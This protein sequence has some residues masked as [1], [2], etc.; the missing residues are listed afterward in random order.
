VQDQFARARVV[1][2]AV[3]TSIFSVATVATATS[4]NLHS[5][6]DQAILTAVEPASET[7]E[8]TDGSVEIADTVETV[9]VQ[10][11]A[12][13]DLAPIGHRTYSKADNLPSSGHVATLALSDPHDP[14]LPASTFS[15]RAQQTT[16]TETDAYSAFEQAAAGSQQAT[17]TVVAR[18]PQAKPRGA[19]RADRA[20]IVTT[21]AVLAYAPEPSTLDAPFDAVLRG[22][23][24]EIVVQGG[25][26]SNVTRPRPDPEELL[27]WLEGRALGQFAPD[28][29]D[30]VKNPLP[31]SVHTAKEQKCLA[32]GIYF[33]ARGEPE[34]GQAAVAQV[35]LNRVRNPT[36]PDTI[37]GVV[38]QNKG[39][40]NR[41]QFSF[42]CDGIPDKV[43]S[44][45]AWSTARSIASD[46]T[47]G[48]I[49]IE[50]VGDSTHY[51]ADYVRPKWARAMNKM[52][53]IGA[54][55]FYRTRLGGWS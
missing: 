53:K 28:Q 35:I 44:G 30:W 24:D 18:L 39:W 20:Q 32:E 46:V 12:K 17:V 40:R 5:A 50:E 52:E 42:A 3:A 2:L 1:K 11:P 4:T 23:P 15:R 9:T 19:A 22:E 38:Y 34:S 45:P 47:E 41:C 29:H 54:H 6:T 31:D 16:S 37:C 7:R 13:G 25:D 33:E 51:Y 21:S 10:R 36:Y 26:D 49:W 48:K 55:L 8:L 27:G 14:A 43:H